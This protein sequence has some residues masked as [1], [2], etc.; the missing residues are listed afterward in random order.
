ME[1]AERFG[2]NPMLFP[3]VLAALFTGV[4]LAAQSIARL[5]EDRNP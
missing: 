1:M 2:M 3:I 4:V 5:L